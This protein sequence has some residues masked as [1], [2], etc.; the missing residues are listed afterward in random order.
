MAREK[1]APGGRQPSTRVVGFQ[2]SVRAFMGACSP[3][4]PMN[5]GLL[6]HSIVG[7]V[8]PDLTITR[9]NHNQIMLT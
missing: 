7:R 1:W 8:Y 4:N 6:F 3:M 5:R 9:L 2:F